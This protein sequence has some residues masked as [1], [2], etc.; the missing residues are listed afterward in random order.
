MDMGSASVGRPASLDCCNAKG[1]K[2]AAA[3]VDKDPL[4]GQIVGAQIIIRVAARAISP[5]V[6]VTF[7]PCKSSR[8][9]FMRRGP[10]A[11]HPSQHGKK[12]HAG[13]IEIE[14]TIVADGDAMSVARQIG[15]QLF[16]TGESRFCVNNPFGCTG[17]LENGGKW[18]IIAL[19]TVSLIANAKAGD[20]H[21]KIDLTTDQM[22]A[23]DDRLGR[24]RKKRSLDIDGLTV[25]IP[26]R[27]KN[28]LGHK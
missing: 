20:D 7:R 3:R 16:G 12:A 17:R 22:L 24:I 8:H 25:C 27:L 23:F 21:V 4:L 14:Q 10:A 5:I 11:K 9:R 15:Q 26:E 2:H 6:R 18:S 1:S 13:L 19:A 28:G